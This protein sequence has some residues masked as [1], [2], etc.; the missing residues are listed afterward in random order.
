[1]RK[2]VALLPLKANSE[3]VSGKNFREFHG[4][5]LFRWTLDALLSLEK[6]EQVIIN[7]DA[8]DLLENIGLP[9]SD[10]ILIRDR[11]TEIC[12]DLVS[13]NKVIADDLNAVEASAYLMTHTT[14]PLISPTTFSDA[15]DSYFKSTQEGFDSVFSVNKYQSRFFS[16]QLNP[17]NHDPDNLIRTQDLQPMYEENSCLYL[18]SR[19]S[20]IK[21]QSRIGLNPG[22]FVT[23]FSE[24]VDIDDHDTWKLAEAYYTLFN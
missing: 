24:S 3:R 5:P 13:M 15:I 23:P 10:K 16:D 6:V 19:E 21:K 14:N 9:D 22:V 7:T 12:G 17:I 8:R 2:L 20:F 1:M 4:K 18:F 11:K